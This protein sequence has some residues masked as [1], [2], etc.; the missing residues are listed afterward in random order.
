MYQIDSN[1]VGFI[2]WWV[3]KPNFCDIRRGFENEVERKEIREREARWSFGWNREHRRAPKGGI[4][5]GGFRRVLG[6]LA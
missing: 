2:V 3:L 4:G 5:R 6:L 1:E